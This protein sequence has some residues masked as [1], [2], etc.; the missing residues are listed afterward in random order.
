MLRLACC[1]L[2]EA[3]V[4]VCCA[5]HDALLIEAPAGEIGGAV[6]ACQQAMEQAS[7]LVLG[8]LVLRT[9]AKL[10]SYPDRYTDERGV[11]MWGRVFGLLGRR[12]AA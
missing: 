10:V 4:S 12:A 6:E 9:E 7:R 2:T 5:V 11:A 3:G 8:N 1:L